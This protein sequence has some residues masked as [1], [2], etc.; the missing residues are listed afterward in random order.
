M[1]RGKTKT[2]AVA[3]CDMVAILVRK[4]NDNANPTCRTRLGVHN[5]EE[6]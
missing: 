3:L 2:T 5:Q 1:S 6:D 4:D